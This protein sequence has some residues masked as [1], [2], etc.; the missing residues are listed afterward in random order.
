MTLNAYQMPKHWSSIYQSTRPDFRKLDKSLG[1]KLS[2]GREH[3]AAK[4]CVAELVETGSAY[5]LLFENKK[6]VN[7][8]NLTSVCLRRNTLR[9]E[10]WLTT[11]L[12]LWWNGH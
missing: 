5:L 1:Q 7:K 11:T 4:C 10:Y 2:M 12:N 6:E 8:R 9:W 3:L